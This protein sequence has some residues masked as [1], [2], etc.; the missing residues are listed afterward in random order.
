MS[1]E[2]NNQ[3]IEHVC[4]TGHR[5]IDPPRASLILPLLDQ[6]LRSLIRLGA[7]Q[8]YAGGALGFDTIAAI[9]VLKLK[10]DFPDVRLNLILPCKNQTKMWNDK[11]RAIYDSILQAADS[12]EFV[13]ENYTSYCMHERN[14]RL[15]DSSQICIAYCEHSGGGS[16]YT[17]SYALKKEKEVLNIADLI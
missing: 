15:V 11:D 14:R 2:M 9:A 7:T 4:F 10:K 17:M 1:Q 6:I 16:A 3:K 12:V 13:C 5:S 8:F